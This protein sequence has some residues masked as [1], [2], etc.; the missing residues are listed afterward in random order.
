M[1][2]G[3][4]IGY[5]LA[6]VCHLEVARCDQNWGVKD[7]P[8]SVGNSHQLRASAPCCDD[9]ANQFMRFDEESIVLV[10]LYARGR[11]ELLVEQCKEVTL[12]KCIIN[13]SA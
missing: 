1:I 2:G 10:A 13:K 6:E 5:L 7:A 4:C 9:V 12:M 8:S 3:E 11:S